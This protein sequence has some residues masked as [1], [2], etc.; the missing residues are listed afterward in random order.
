MKRVT[1]SI[2]SNYQP[3]LA[4]AV[5]D[6]LWSSEKPLMIRDIVAKLNK[7]DI[8]SYDISSAVR[9]LLLRWE[10]CGEVVKHV[11]DK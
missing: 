1:Y 7:M 4:G 6:I 9:V 8:A 5:R 3:S 10:K 11:E 2:N